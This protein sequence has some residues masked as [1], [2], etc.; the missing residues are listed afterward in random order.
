MNEQN[1]LELNEVLGLLMF[2]MFWDLIYG[3]I[4]YFDYV[5]DSVKKKIP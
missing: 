4:D 3:N 1:D 5:R 2:Y